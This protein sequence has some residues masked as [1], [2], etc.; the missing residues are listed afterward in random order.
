M[1]CHHHQVCDNVHVEM[2][3][4]ELEQQ[5]GQYYATHG[6]T[7]DEIQ[8]RTNLLTDPMQANRGTDM[9]HIDFIIPHHDPEKLRQYSKFI[10][11]ECIL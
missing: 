8:S 9:N 2:I 10:A 4:D 5:L 6:H 1:K 7:F 11:R 3:L